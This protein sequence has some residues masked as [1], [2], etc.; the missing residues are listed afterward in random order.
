[1][2]Y[3]ELTITSRKTANCNSKRRWLIEPN[4]TIKIGRLATSEVMMPADGRI[5]RNHCEL[6]YNEKRKDFTIR[7]LSKFGT[8]LADGK[9]MEKS[10]Q[11]TLKDGDV[12][13]ILSPE[14]M[15][16]VVIET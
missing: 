11:Y 9:P 5:S 10:K 14:Y 6:F 8:F 4:R 3:L 13:Y 7:D 16:R 1:M 2:A 12:F 15:F